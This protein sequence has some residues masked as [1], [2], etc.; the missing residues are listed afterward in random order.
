MG[1]S[2]PSVPKPPDPEETA[3]AQYK[4]NKL[5]FEDV[6]RQGTLNQNAPSGSVSYTRDPNG[7]PTGVTTSLSPALQGAFDTTI[8]AAGSQ[9]GMLPTEAFN[10]NVNGA[11]IRDAYVR[12]GLN[13]VEDL[14]NRQDQARNVTYAERGLPMGSEIY[15][16]AENEVAKNRNDYLSQ[17]SN[18]AYQAGTAEEQR[19]FGNQMTQYFTPFQAGISALNMGSGI[20]GMVPGANPLPIQNLQ[21]GNYAD[22]ANRNYAAA[23]AQ[24]NQDAANQSAGL[25]N[26]LKFGG[27]VLGSAIPGGGTIASS[28][29][30]FSDADL[31]ENIE[32]IG[33]LHDGQEP[34]PIYEWSYKGDP[35]RHIGPM[36]QDLAETNPELVYEHPSGYL[37]IDMNAPTR[38][39]LAA[40]LRAG[41]TG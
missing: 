37:M 24:Y 40:V 7:N 35:E 1:K 8:G 30:G 14:W 31:K 32:P 23:V 3:A 13:N 4:Y 5:A 21:P 2:A 36:A 9:L 34:L 26:F 10:P 25:G 11:D 33:E 41:M 27:S 17:L 20:L 6:L 19:Q 29:F 15:N 16:N 39:S 22:T 28:L 12:Q 18:Q 38:P